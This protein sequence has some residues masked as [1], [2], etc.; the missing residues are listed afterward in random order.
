MCRVPWCVL[1]GNILSPTFGPTCCVTKSA[2]ALV[3]NPAQRVARR[4]NSSNGKRVGERRE[5]KK[6]P[7]CRD[8]THIKL[9]FRYYSQMAFS[10]DRR[11]P[12][13]IAYDDERAQ[14]SERVAICVEHIVEGNY[15]ALNCACVCVCVR[16]WERKAANGSRSLYRTKFVLGKFEPHE[17]CVRPLERSEIIYSNL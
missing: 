2:H 16:K 1:C 7:R 17:T 15:T 13:T 4:E 9:R 12:G 14:A 5:E 11:A 8:K 6:L 3:L 10:N